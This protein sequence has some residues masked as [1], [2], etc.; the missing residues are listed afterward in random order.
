MLHLIKM[1][2]IVLARDSAAVLA[3]ARLGGSPDPFAP[4]LIARPCTLSVALSSCD[5]RSPMA[6]RLRATAYGVGKGYCRAQRSA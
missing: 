1:W 5:G 3:L 4:I 2:L 6:S